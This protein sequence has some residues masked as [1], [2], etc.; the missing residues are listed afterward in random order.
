[1]RGRDFGDAATPEKVSGELRRTRVEVIVDDGLV[2]DLVRRVE[3]S[4]RELPVRWRT[5][6]VI[7]Q[8]RIA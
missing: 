7:E 4:R 1:M 2:A 8:G 6:P 3:T 5:V